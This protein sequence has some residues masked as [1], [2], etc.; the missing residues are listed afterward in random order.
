M[1]PPPS[2]STRSPHLASPQQAQMREPIRRLTEEHRSEPGVETLYASGRVWR[3]V[4]LNRPKSRIVGTLECT[5]KVQHL[6]SGCAASGSS[7]S[8]FCGGGAAGSGRGGRFATKHIPAVWR[9]RRLGDFSLTGGGGPRRHFA[10]GPH[11]GDSEVL[12]RRGCTFAVVFSSSP[13]AALYPPGTHAPP[14]TRLRTDR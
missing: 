6:L 1:S 5:R 2:C 9:P 13:D 10:L 4:Q 7:S 11:L 12:V 8:S 14:P 3:D